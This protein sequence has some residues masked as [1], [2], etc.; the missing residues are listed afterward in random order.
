M[1]LTPL[2]IEIPHIARDDPG[3]E[4]WRWIAS[5]LLCLSIWIDPGNNLLAADVKIQNH[6][7]DVTINPSQHTLIA[8]DTMRLTGIDSKS[9]PI[10]LTLNQTLTV[11]EIRIGDTIIPFHTKGLESMPQEKSEPQP[12]KKLGH[13]EKP[14]HI[15][16]IELPNWA[17]EF[18]TLDLM[19]IYQ[20][21]I[22][23]PPRAS[24]GLRYVRP[25]QTNGH[26]GSEG[27]YLTSETQWYPD[28]PR[29][30]ATYSIRVTLPHD[31]EVVTQGRE[32][33]RT[34]SQKQLTTEWQVNARSE[35]LTL[36]ANHY[37]ITRQ[38]WHGIQIATY[39]FPE[40][41][42]LAE[43]YLKAT[44]KYL[45]V[46][47]QLL[48]PYPFPKFA[49][50]ENFFPSGIGL[51]SFTLLGSRVIKRGYTQPYS[52]GH[53]IVHSWLGNSVLND[54]S[55]GNWVEGLTTYLANYY[56]EELSE[57][58]DQALKIRRRMIYE[59]SL[60]AV[61]EHEYPLLHF[62][63][64]ESRI[65]NAIGYQKAAMVFHML[66]REIGDQAF[67]SGIH[68]LI[69]NWS[70]RY[71]EW[72]T[73]EEVFTKTSG[74]DLRWFFTQWVNQPGAPSIRILSSQVLKDIQTDSQI[75]IRLNISQQ[76]PPYRLRLPVIVDLA[77]GKTIRTTIVLKDSSQVVTI[78]APS[79]PTRVSID[80]DYETFRR[81]NRE[82]IP[83]M[84]N[85]W[86]TD[87]DRTIVLR[88]GQAEAE[89]SSFQSILQRIRSE[90][91]PI[92]QKT[93]TQTTLGDESTLVLGGPETNRLTS[94]SLEGC[95]DTIRLE[96][97]KALIQGQ[98]FEG[99]E[100]A[101]L[102]SCP[103]PE[104]PS[105]VATVF[106]GF[107]HKAVAQVA[108]LLFFYGWDSYLVFQNGRVIARGTFEPPVKD[109]EIQ[110]D[111]V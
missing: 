39:L 100:I 29:S 75:A 58:L 17:T 41:A 4:V 102:I 42:H 36:A 59:Y 52:L 99:P 107:S 69:E 31:W 65:D 97:H 18:S 104:Y 98:V 101:F 56:Y 54:F 25:S 64:K 49:V 95:S 19:I 6:N 86:T 70:G 96:H 87:R 92:V 84:L 68:A 13:H 34:S 88:K 15:L 63:H 38:E 94:T 14:E 90:E 11:Q 77:N 40:D 27:V 23:D 79:Q 5:G 16:E 30:L 28:I 105:H 20:G 78:S 81:L 67:F 74:R 12:T 53:E 51:P 89:N 60:Y 109:L 45:D 85:I 3:Y 35:A 21:T 108:R 48:G 66:R 46:Y 82:Q 106:F 103:N 32:M 110:L 2:Y 76:Q 26:I 55:T 71:T 47:T 33:S 80:Q 9:S 83:P 57:N 43:Q 10:R 44:A 91:S 8:S 73:L 93:D 111:T 1:P 62:H 72:G 61:P 7:L 50:V 24:T 37:V 22:D